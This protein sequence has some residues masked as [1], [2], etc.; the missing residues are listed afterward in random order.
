MKAVI[1]GAGIGGLTAA[2]ALQRRGVAVTVVE[3]ADHLAAGGAALSIWPNALRALDE[4][5]IGPDARAHAALGGNSGVRRSDGRWLARSQLGPAIQARYGDPLILIARATLADQLIAELAPDTVRFGCAA[6][7]LHAGATS[8][9]AVLHT[10]DGDHEADLV[11]IADGIGSQLRPLLFPAAAGPRYAGYT[12]W[13][14]LVPATGELESS[15]TWGPDGQR[16]AVLPLADDTC[17]CYATATVPAATTFQDDAVELRRRFG[18]W[19]APIDGIVQALANADVLRND[20]QELPPLPAMHH[21]RV[22]LLG[23]AAHAM[24]PDLGQGACQAIEDALVLAAELDPHNPDS[25]PSSLQRYTANRLPRTS[26]IA[27]R[28]HQAGALYQR[29]LL[30]Q[31][32][33]ARLLG[34]L[35]P[36]M[37]ARSLRSVVDW[38]PP[39]L[40]QP[41]HQ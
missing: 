19:H 4:L 10:S 7:G 31:T 3:R 37:I 15:E 18:S 30:I 28:S 9:Q 27:R 39:H 17:Y 23:D 5:S 13:R 11:A 20:I 35:P 26:A 36:M 8:A 32:A 29:P 16:F 21:Q 6:T 25:V 33:A 2:L 38:H 40:A 1:A 41:G 14:M 24:T 12:A 22:A 34:V